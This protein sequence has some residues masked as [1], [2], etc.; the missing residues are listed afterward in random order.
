MMSRKTIFEI[1]FL[2]KK[3]LFKERKIIFY[4]QN[5]S[6]SRAALLYKALKKSYKSWSNKYLLIYVFISDLQDFFILIKLKKNVRSIWSMQ[7]GEE[8]N[9][10]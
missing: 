1:N 3:T 8:S 9:I 5:L 4:A 7:D 2:E 10:F 6:F